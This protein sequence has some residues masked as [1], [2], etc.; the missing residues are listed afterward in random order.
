VAT[1]VPRARPT[2]GGS[3]AAYACPGEGARAA[4]A[5]PDRWVTRRWVP[6]GLAEDR[7]RTCTAQA[8]SYPSHQGA[9]CG[10]S[11]TSGHVTVLRPLPAAAPMRA[12]PTGR[13]ADPTRST[14]R[15]RTPCGAAVHWCPW[16]TDASLRAGHPWRSGSKPCRSSG[17]REQCGCVCAHHR[18][19]RTRTCTTKRRRSAGLAVG[20]PEI[21]VL[22]VGAVTVWAPTDSCS[23]LGVVAIVRSASGIQP[24]AGARARARQVGR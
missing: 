24:R 18:R 14:L 15:R 12:S 11:R 22:V 20:R 21:P 7:W 8:G 19:T 2:V 13:R 4:T 1:Q 9:A 6:S 5:Q 23:P 3:G 10:S 17:S 16:Q